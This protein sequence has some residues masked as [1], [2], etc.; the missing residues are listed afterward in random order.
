MFLAPIQLFIHGQWWSINM[1][2]LPQI[3]QWWL[4]GGLTQSHLRQV[5]SYLR[6]ILV[7]SLSEMIS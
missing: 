1:T 3:E 5:R 2:H 6:I 4:L 7:R